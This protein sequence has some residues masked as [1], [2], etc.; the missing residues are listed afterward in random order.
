MRK[1][2]IYGSKEFARV[3]R[4]IIIKCKYEFVG[5]IDDYSTGHE[6][7]GNYASIIKKFSPDSYEM[8]IAIGYN[9]LSARRSVYK[10]VIEDG[11]RL[12]VIIHPNAYVR[13][14]SNIGQG[15]IIMAGAIVDVN[16]RVGELC[17]LWPGVVVNHDSNIGENTF[18][19]PNSTVCGVVEI[20]ENCFIGAGAIIVDHTIVP[21][22]SFVKAGEVFTG[23]KITKIK[24]KH[25]K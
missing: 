4:D 11:Y 10:K 25:K 16:V 5:Y 22:G 6:I 21:A 12:P 1:I 9:N 13:D 7:I 20:K 2:L 14:I 23:K 8:V 19:S 15:S 3:V 24:E 17:V 18:L